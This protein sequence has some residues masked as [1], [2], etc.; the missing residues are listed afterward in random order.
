MR[1]R[2]L[3]ITE[4]RAGRVIEAWVI[5]PEPMLIEDETKSASGAGLLAWGFMGM[6]VGN[7]L[8]AYVW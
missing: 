3:R 5:E 8:V 6:I 2:Y 7:M 1:R 4:T